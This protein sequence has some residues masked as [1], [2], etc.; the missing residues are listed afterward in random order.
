MKRILHL[1]SLLLLVTGAA[2]GSQTASKAGGTPAPPLPKGAQRIV[3]PA[4]PVTQL[5]RMTPEQRERA[6]ER[7]GAKQQE[8]ARKLLAWFDSLPKDQQD[9]QIRRAEHFAQLPPEKRL[10]VRQLVAAANQLP[11]N[12]KRAVGAALVR[13]QQMGDQQRENT[14]RRPLFQARFSAEEMKII[15]GLADA[16]MGGPPE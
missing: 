13:L 16:W 5:F 7:A 9:L 4:N 1:G 2:L 3:N 8:D 6:L 14:L 12:R 11:P 10:E 15:S